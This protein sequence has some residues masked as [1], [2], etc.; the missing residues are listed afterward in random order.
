MRAIGKVNGKAN[1]AFQ[2][3]ARSVR[4]CTHRRC[5]FHTQQLRTIGE[6]FWAPTL[7]RVQGYRT[8][9]LHLL[10][11]S[12]LVSHELAVLGAADPL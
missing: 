3:R 4:A 9:A 8:A 11:V 6:A 5:A 7:R 2:R 10:D 1:S 12:E